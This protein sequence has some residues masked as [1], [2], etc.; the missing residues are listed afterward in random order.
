LIEVSLK[1]IKLH[2]QN[3]KLPWRSHE[4]HAFSKIIKFEALGFNAKVGQ[5]RQKFDKFC[6]CSFYISS[7]QIDKK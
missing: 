2:V 1:Q 5:F 6:I 3:T 4:R 7:E